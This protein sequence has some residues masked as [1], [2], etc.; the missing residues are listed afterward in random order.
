MR[1]EWSERRI[2]LGTH[3]LRVADLGAGE[4][5]FVCLHGLAD[6]LDIWG[7]LAAPLAERGRVVLVEQRA[8]GSSTAPR[9]PYRREDL[10]GDIVAVLDHFGIAGAV[11]VGHSMGGIVALTTALAAAERV[12]GLVLLGTASQ[13]S[14]RA[15]AWYEQIAQAAERDGLD[16]MARAIYGSTGTRRIAGDPAGLA[17]V[18]RCLA[19]LFSDPLTPRLGAIRCPVALVVGDRD[20]MRPRAS[21]II[22]DRIDGAILAVVANGGHWLHVD[23][24][25]RVL[26]A[27]DERWPA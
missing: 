21:E 22:R 15:A 19:S 3:T 8:H 10:A 2:D 6:T 9:G 13:C 12:S 16:G 14:E 27:I 23:A 25:P 11:L 18:T 24:P 17:Q 1:A 4:R 5:V 26:A 20:P 7:A